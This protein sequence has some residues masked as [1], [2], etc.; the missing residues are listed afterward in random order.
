MPKVSMV[1][2]LVT[3]EP[4]EA[5][6]VEGIG[7]EKRFKAVSENYTLRLCSCEYLCADGN[8]GNKYALVSIG[9]SSGFEDFD[10]SSVDRPRVRCRADDQS[11]ED[12]R[13]IQ[14]GDQG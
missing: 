4:H 8:I 12:L 3:V 1:E 14:I 5:S 6:G 9:H 10:K 7:F 13:E 2:C 11:V